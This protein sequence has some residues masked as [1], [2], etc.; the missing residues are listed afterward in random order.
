MQTIGNDKPRQNRLK[1]HAELLRAFGALSD[2]I[3]LARANFRGSNF[4]RG[5]QAFGVATQDLEQHRQVDLQYRTLARGTKLHAGR[6]GNACAQSLKSL[7]SQV[8]TIA[9]I[10]HPKSQVLVANVANCPEQFW[11]CVSS[12]ARDA[13]ASSSCVESEATWV[14]VAL[15]AWG[16]DFSRLM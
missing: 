13:M 6:P 15:R 1:L 5:V 12:S 3:D 10:L 8:V 16:F 7:K 4:R 11:T 14:R 9:S 2:A